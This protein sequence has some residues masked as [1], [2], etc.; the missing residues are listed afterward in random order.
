MY[1]LVRK[2]FLIVQR[3]VAEE[4]KNLQSHERKTM[5]EIT[6]RCVV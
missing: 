5:A 3:V 4:E 1:K 2:W 6:H